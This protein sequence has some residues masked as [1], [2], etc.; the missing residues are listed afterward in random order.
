MPEKEELYRKLTMQDIT[1]SDYNHAKRIS[2]DFKILKLRKYLKK[3]TLLADVF[4]TLEKC[5]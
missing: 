5:T 2:M 4:E 1:D 3:Y